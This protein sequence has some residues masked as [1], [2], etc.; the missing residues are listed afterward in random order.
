MSSLQ[1]PCALFQI[2]VFVALMAIV[3]TALAEPEPQPSG[4]IGAGV[5]APAVAVG[6][7]GLGHGVVHG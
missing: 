1:L 3:A 7:W 5:L 6:G 2:F 4:I